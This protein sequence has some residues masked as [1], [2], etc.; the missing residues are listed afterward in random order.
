MH[1]FPDHSPFERR[2]QQAEFEWIRSSE[3][4]SRALAENYIGLPFEV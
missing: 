3:T 1:R 4:A 2:M